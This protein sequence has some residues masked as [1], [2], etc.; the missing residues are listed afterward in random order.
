MV[1]SHSSSRKGF[2]NAEEVQAFLTRNAGISKEKVVLEM[3][4]RFKL[5]YAEAD[6]IYTDWRKRYIAGEIEDKEERNENKN[7]SF[8]AYIKEYA[9]RN[10]KGYSAKKIIKIIENINKYGVKKAS[11]VLKMD[12]KDVTTVYGNAKEKGFIIPR[13]TVKRAKYE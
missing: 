4:R 2:K 5:S 3:L 6:K 10:R 7:Y 8:E 13:I 12:I 11:E 1:I 9:K